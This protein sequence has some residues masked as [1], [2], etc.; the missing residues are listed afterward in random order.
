MKRISW[1]CAISWAILGVLHW[2]AFAQNNVPLGTQKTQ[3]PDVVISEVCYW[4]KAGEPEWIELA[5]V[6]EQPVDIKGWQL[7]D[8]QNLACV[9]SETVL[10][11]PPQ[12]Y[13]VVKLDGTG[14]PPTIFENHHA[15][16]HSPRGVAGNLLGNT[17]GQVALYT[18]TT[19]Y[20]PPEIQSFVAWGRSP[21][22]II[23]DALRSKVWSHSTDIVKGSS[24]EIEALGVAQK[25]QQGGS[26]SLF[27]APDESGYTFEHWAV[28]ASDEIN[29]GESGRWKRSPATVF[30]IGEKT[31]E[32]GLAT[33]SLL[34]LEEGIQYQFQVC[35]DRDC[36]EIFAEAT[37]I[38]PAYLLEKPVPN[39]T[40]YYW[41]ARLIYPNGV[42][43]GWTDTRALTHGYPK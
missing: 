4:P 2:P 27:E 15:V 28:F 33:L 5:N 24:L 3:T 36:R 29:P 10:V 30:P 39:H 13:L 26:I 16:A 37:Q 17:G 18:E 9:V 42:P 1:P 12:S 31:S 23:A 25:M 20:E 40:T 35:K 41:R 34:R 43:S 7:L 6:S 32:D 8:G 21:G 19:R 22:S 14:Q 11:M 38:H